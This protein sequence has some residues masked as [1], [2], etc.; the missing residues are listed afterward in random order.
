MKNLLLKLIAVGKVKDP[1]Y[2]AKTAEFLTRL[3]AYGKLEAV[4]LRDD[5]VEKESQAI[6]KQ[7]E[8]ERGMVI[9]LDEHGRTL[10]SPA[11]AQIMAECDRRMVFVVGGAY[12]FTDAVRERA[13]LVLSL[14]P[15]TFTHEMARLVLAE[16][17]Y[18]AATILARAEGF[19][20]TLR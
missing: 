9:V 18:R 17:L 12:G 20:T 14:S 10:S 15:M 11:L 19:F 16:Q 1:H 3:G 6:L 13:D 2:Q 4:E 7:L 5:T 8:H